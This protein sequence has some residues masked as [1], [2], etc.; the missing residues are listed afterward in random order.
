MW[1]QADGAMLT[2]T[3]RALGMGGNGFSIS[4][5][6]DNSQGNVAPLTANTSGHIL[7][8]GIDGTCPDPSGNY[9]RTDLSAI[10]RINRAARDWSSSF[11]VALNSYGIDATA[12]F[13]MELQHGDDS[14]GT[15]IAQR[16][17]NG[18]PA[19]LTT[20]ALQTNF[21]PISTGFWQQV[22]T[23]MAGVMAASGLVPYLQ[24]G[25]VQW[26]YFPGPTAT[27]VTEPGLPLYDNY[28]TTSFAAAHGRPMALIPNRY[29]EPDQLSAECTFLRGLIGV[30]TR[31]IRDFVRSCFPNARFAVLYPVDVNDTPLNQSIN[32]PSDDWTPAHLT[33]LKTENFT[34]TFERDLTKAL[35]SI[36]M[37]FNPG[38]SPAQSSHLIGIGDYTTSWRA[39]EQ[40]ASGEQLE[41]VV[42]FALDQFCLIGYGLPLQYDM[43]RAGFM[44]A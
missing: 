26:W 24:F 34:Y 2:I 10:P 29:A 28:T 5:S 27:V 6:T 25:E 32:F 19:W 42:L 30:F 14:V 4:A 13:S 12:S 44:G 11:F 8:G 35:Q 40:L 22:Y 39:E 21:G 9:W 37:P 17:P 1:A 18:D 36:Q 43:R 38:F 15:G 23:D 7:T 31:T 16:Y 3:A 41:S 33:C 20:P